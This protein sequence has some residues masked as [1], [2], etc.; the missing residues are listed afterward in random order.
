VSRTGIGT[1]VVHVRRAGEGGRNRPSDWHGVDG[2][3]MV[4]VLL[5]NDGVGSIKSTQLPH[6][7]TD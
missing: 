6:A 7:E 1:I 4:N 3:G 2:N 5:R